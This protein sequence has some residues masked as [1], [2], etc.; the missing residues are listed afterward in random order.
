[1]TTEHNVSSSPF[2]VALSVCRLIKGAK[3]ESLK[4]TYF[5]VHEVLCLWQQQQMIS[6]LS[7]FS[8]TAPAISNR[9]ILWLIHFASPQKELKTPK[10][11]HII[12]A[13]FITNPDICRHLAEVQDQRSSLVFSHRL[14]DERQAVSLCRCFSTTISNIISTPFMLVA[15]S[16]LPPLKQDISE[17]RVEGQTHRFQF[18]TLKCENIQ[19][20]T[21]ASAAV[22]RVTEA[23][24]FI[25]VF[26]YLCMW[27]ATF[28]RV[29]S[30]K[31]WTLTL[32]LS[33][34]FC[35][36]GHAAM[37]GSLDL[38]RLKVCIK[39]T[40]P[41]LFPPEVDRDSAVAAGHQHS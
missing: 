30:G 16:S 12:F 15:G 13:F 35:D 7:L 2:S 17:G 23:S 32:L 10:W 37:H 8:V 5:Q 6:S 31:S 18:D 28:F 39:Q 1:M 29:G 41:V 25:H 27:L 14:S 26:I 36:G 19:N 24:I 9:F 4:K 33:E 34:L 21:L 3:R 20:H 40:L 38:K 11:V 22:G